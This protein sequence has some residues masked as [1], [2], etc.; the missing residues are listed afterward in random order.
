MK[1]S[2]VQTLILLL[3]F[4]YLPECN[5]YGQ[6]PAD[7][8]QKITVTTVQSKAATIT[9]QYT[10]RINSHHHIEVRAL[11]DGY[12]QEILV[13]E[14]QAVKQGD[15]IFKFVPVLY[16]ARLDSE[17]A[18][19]DIAQL[20]LNN[21]KRLAEKQGVSQFEVKLFE[22]KLA[23]AAA[24][25]ELAKAELNFTNVRAPFDGMIDRLPRQQGSLVLKGETLTNLFDNTVMWVYF[26]VPEKRYLEYWAEQVQ[27]QQSPDIAL[28]LADHSEFPQTGKIG[29]ILATFGN[30]TGDIAF[31]ADF[32]NPDGLLRHGQSGTLVINRVL[33]D[34]IV[35]PQ[36]ASF[37]NLAKRYVYVVDKDNVAHQREIVIQN[38]LEDLFVIKKGVGVG[39]K[40]VVDGVRLVRD[41]DKVE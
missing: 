37:E 35:I 34:A 3:I 15:L 16:Q 22:A 11:G 4:L 9:Q 19:R 20:E 5:A 38:E 29:A 24:K 40:I 32:P 14:G 23:K 41:G 13:K 26:N 7:E 2:R 12:L 21:T 25:V 10:C 28:M 1:A 18:E 6:K 17:L 27:N 36:R 8:A 31:R 30:E 39:D 33:K